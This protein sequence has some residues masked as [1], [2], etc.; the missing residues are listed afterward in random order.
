M[1]LP[2][3]EHEASLL[4]GRKNE[5][6]ETAA[7]WSR[8]LTIVEHNAKLTA[9]SQKNTD[10]PTASNDKPAVKRDTS[11]MREVLQKLSKVH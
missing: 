9:Q 6:E 5:G 1:T 7:D 2:P 10:A 11:R 4:A 8:V 3:R